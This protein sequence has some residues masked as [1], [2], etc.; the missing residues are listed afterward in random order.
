MRRVGQLSGTHRRMTAWERLAVRRP[1]ERPKRIP[2][3]TSPKKWAAIMMRLRET[4][5]AQRKMPQP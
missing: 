3:M 1:R 4:R 5:V 2:T